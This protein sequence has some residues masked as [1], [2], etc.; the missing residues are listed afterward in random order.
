MVSTESF[1]EAS[2]N[3]VKAEA[4]TETVKAL[5]TLQESAKKDLLWTLGFIVG[6]VGT[7]TAVI[8]AVLA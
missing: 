1:I 3:R 7:A 8:L 2:V 5:L 4:D 6:V